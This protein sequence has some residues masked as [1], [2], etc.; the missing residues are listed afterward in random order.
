[1]G[2]VINLHERDTA[3]PET[4][5]DGRLSGQY[6]AGEPLLSYVGEE[7]ALA[8][9]IVN[10]RGGVTVERADGS[11]TYKPGRNYRTMVA[12]TD[13]RLLV[14]VG[15][16]GDDGDRIVPVPLS[17]ITDVD[18]ESSFLGGALLVTTDA[19]EQWSIPCRD[20]LDPVRSYLVRAKQA[21]SRV[22]RRLTEADE[23]IEAAA[24][25]LED[26]YEAALET[27]GDA[28][29]V[30]ARARSELDDLE[31][32]RG[33]LANADFE[34]REASIRTV[35]RRAHAGIAADHRAR[36]HE[37]RDDERYREA[38]ESFEQALAVHERAL[39]IDG[40]EPPDEQLRERRDDTE[41]ELTAFE[42]A[43]A[44]DA[45]D[46]LEAARG[47]DDPEPRIEAL[48]DA[49]EGH[50]DLLGLCWGPDS[51]FKGDSEAIRDRIV[52][53]V[54]D[55]IAART[56]A[57]R[58]SLVAADRLAV[59]DRP[60]DALAE[61][62]RA[63]EQLDAARALAGE[64]LP[65]HLDTL[66]TWARSIDDQ[67]ARIDDGDESETVA[68][69]G[70]TVGGI[71]TVDEPD[72]T[73]DID[74]EPDEATT[75]DAAPESLEERVAALDQSSF[76]RLIADV[77]QELGWQTTAFTASVDQYDVMAT[78]DDPIELRMLVWAVH[79]PHGNLDTAAVD[80]CTTDRANVDRA[81]VAAIVT[82]G[83]IPDAVRERASEHN[84]K[85]LD[86]DDLLALLERERLEHLVDDARA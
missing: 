21:W 43:P 20:D 12:V 55:L 11:E 2:T 79:R 78:R 81:D 24:D 70:E 76:T 35:Q 26:D 19:G 34:R 63:V 61:C 3:D 51:S 80:R 46:R 44:A 52:E 22:E 48:E 53:I 50:R 77:W 75:V 45:A 25:R 10:K 56:D 84:V 4:V 64:L 58:R 23:R 6:L 60:E 42:R 86:R 39:A 38:H 7:E 17:T 49:L 37:Y 27:V 18:T 14:A 68:A 47:I 57:V 28:T 67:R 29:S 15:G 71:T 62:D 41:R 5:A 73:A 54:E 13:V 59:R 16:A 83:S 33:V 40:V 65:E 8:F 9:V 66:D 85:L 36:A 82:T 30:L 31:M 74:V 32:G 1:M 72:R 69:T